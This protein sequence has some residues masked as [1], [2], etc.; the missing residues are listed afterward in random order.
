[1][2]T[3]RQLAFEMERLHKSCRRL[4]W[5]NPLLR[6]D[7]VRAARRRHPAMLPH[8]DRFM[9]VH[10]LASLAELVGCWPGT[11]TAPF[12]PSADPGPTMQLTNQ[13]TL[14]VSQAQAWEALNDIALLQAAIPGCESDHRHRREPVRSAGHR[15]GRPGEGQVQG[16]A[17]A[18]EPAAA[19]QL[20]PALRRPGRRRRPWQGH[21][22][23]RLEATGPR[24]TVLHYTAHAS[25][26]GKMA[27][28][29]SR[30]VDM[31]AQKMATEFF[32]TFN[33]KLQERFKRM[34][35]A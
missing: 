30:L 27:Q 31:A 19:H 15:R 9:P 33:T 1:M 22:E 26:G 21:A 7:Q 10:N 16:Q 6:F 3:R 20:H 29:G 5:L 8:V 12:H 23:I 28:I 11:A 25:V 18:G 14:P 4:I 17:A 32:E 35:S 34:F 2:A 24:S 13:Q